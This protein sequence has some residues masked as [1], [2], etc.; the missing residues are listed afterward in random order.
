MKLI[1][2]ILLTTMAAGTA[3]GQNPDIIQNTKN[4]MNAVAKKAEL[5]QNAVL[6][7]AGVANKP[8]AGTA[9]KAA[10]VS[11]GYKPAV[12]QGKA[13]VVPV[14]AA[15]TPAKATP[16]AV[17]PASVTSP[18]TASN[19]SKPKVAAT[20]SSKASAS[21]KTSAE[22]AKKVPA[23]KIAIAPIAAQPKQ[24][25]QKTGLPARKPV[26]K[27]AQKE[28]KASE[29]KAKE[30]TEAAKSESDPTPAPAETPKETKT[31]TAEGRRDPFVSPVV[32]RSSGPNCSTGKR[33]LA[34]DQILVRGVVRADT[35]MIAVVVN[36]LNKAYFLKENDPVYNGYVLR[37]TGD[38]VVFKETFQ[39]RLGKESTREIVKKI[40]TPAV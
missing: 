2:G 23:T 27:E 21:S 19:Q 25:A 36:S 17:K 29:K 1:T 15:S 10:P 7:S 37:I 4:T 12:A 33:C 39:D 31:I 40:T 6:Q 14:K 38:S 11:S 16:A 20:A 32:N 9:A 8:A 24:G 22:P 28:A 26:A 5:D 30:P 35:G 13:A 34:I 3:L 18:A